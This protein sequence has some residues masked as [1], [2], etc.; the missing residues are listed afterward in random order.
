MSSGNM[1]KP[2]KTDRNAFL[3]WKRDMERKRYAKIKS[4]PE[5]Y[6]KY[7]ENN[8]KKYQ[9]RKEEGNVKII[10]FF[11]C[12][13][14]D[15][16]II[17]S[18][19]GGNILLRNGHR[20][21]TKRL[22]TNGSRAWRCVK[23]KICFYYCEGGDFE[24]IT[25]Q[26]GGDI[27]LRNGYRYTTKRR[28]TNGSRAWRCVK[29]KICK[30]TIVTHN[31][32]VKREEVHKCQPNY[33]ENELKK[34]K[35]KCIDKAETEQIPI[36]EIY[37]Q[38]VHELRSTGFEFVDEIPDYNNIKTAL[39]SHRSRAKKNKQENVDKSEES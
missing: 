10:S 16:E 24:I 35:Q 34:F 25:S 28:N 3:A 11:Y 29:R 8:K 32:K 1:L 31:G 12:E 18:Q 36:S 19:R 22:N 37:T 14:G 17:T 21:T 23:R 15:F 38:T 2:K 27:L 33:V 5:L 7:K 39:Y 4:D 9:K 13:G 20:Y 30:A 6:A 26:R